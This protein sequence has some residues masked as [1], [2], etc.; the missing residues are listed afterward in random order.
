MDDKEFTFHARRDEELCKDGKKHDF[1][2]WIEIDEGRGGTTVC[3]K[4]GLTAIEHSL[5]YGP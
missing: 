3:T 2:G 1:K 5:R 4:C